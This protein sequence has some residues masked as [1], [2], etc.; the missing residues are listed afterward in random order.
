[1]SET[2]HSHKSYQFGAT[3]EVVDGKKRLKIEAEPYFRTCISKFNE[4]EKLSLTVTSHKGKRTTQQNRYYWAYLG[5]IHEET[6]N[7]IEDL[8]ELF[9]GKFL[10]R[11]IVE[12]FGEKVRRKKSTTDLS[13]NDF[14]DYIRKIELFTGILCP[15]TQGYWD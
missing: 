14:S 13:I 15:D 4:G 5:M 12:V 2:V 1:M 11:G 6:G 9:K 3:I 7:E 8:H 10:D